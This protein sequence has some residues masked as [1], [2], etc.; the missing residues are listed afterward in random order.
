MEL[1]SMERRNWNSSIQ[2]VN[3]TH[4]EQLDRDFPVPL[5]SVPSP[6]PFLLI[7]IQL[8]RHGDRSPA[9]TFPSDP[10]QESSWTFGEGG[11]G[12]LTPIGMEQH[13]KLGRIMRSRYVETGFLSHQYTAKE[14]DEDDN[15]LSQ[16]LSLSGQSILIEDCSNSIERRVE[17]DWNVWESKWKSRRNLLSRYTWMANWIRS[18]S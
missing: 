7:S 11:F 10:I 12:V 18:C 5:S 1:S 17:Y 6:S 15:H 16:S 2:W 9:M 3:C 14:V 13:F 8:W 4:S